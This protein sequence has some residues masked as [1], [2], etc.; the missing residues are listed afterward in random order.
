MNKKF[1]LHTE[2]QWGKMK[3]KKKSPEQGMLAPTFMT[4]DLGHSSNLM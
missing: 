1:S 3:K 4:C 2:R